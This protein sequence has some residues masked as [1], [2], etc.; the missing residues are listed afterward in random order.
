MND[1]DIAVISDIALIAD[2]AWMH[3]RLPQFHLIDDQ[4][5]INFYFFRRLAND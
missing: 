1:D 4:Y 2:C 5:S 3:V